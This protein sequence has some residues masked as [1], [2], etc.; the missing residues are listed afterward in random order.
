MHGTCVLICMVHVCSAALRSFI[1]EDF[2]A[3]F[4]VAIAWLY[5]EYAIEEGYVF[6]AQSTLHYE[7][8]LL[9]LLDGARAT[10]DGRDRLFTKLL[11]EAPRLSKPA[12]EIVR[13]YCLD[14]VRCYCLVGWH[15]FN[16]LPV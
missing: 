11:L 3:H 2:K 12:L 14:E 7:S 5:A 8:C 16:P 1:L 4:D 6:C 9:G 13:A 15:L 10:L